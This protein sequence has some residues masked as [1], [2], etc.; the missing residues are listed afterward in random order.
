[1][2]LLATQLSFRAALTGDLEDV[3]AHF[4]DP[5]A[6]TGLAVYHNAY[7]VQLVDCLRETFER[8]DAWLGSEAFTLAAL[9]HIA[10][11]PPHGWTLGVYGEGFDTTLAR[12]YTDDPEVAE[13]A[14]LEWALSKAFAGADAE[15]LAANNL[16][17]VDWDR[18]RLNFVP[19]LQIAE[20]ATNVGAI[21]SALSAGEQP[22][23]AE[24]LP[25]PAA[26]L[27]WRQDYT[28]SFRTIDQNERRAL[29]QMLSGATFGEL[30]LAQVE[31]WGDDEGVRRA[32]EFLGQWLHDG[33]VTSARDSA[34]P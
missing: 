28:P 18:A 7:R 10:E 33:L 34:R 22:P 15:P 32:G 17:A 23:A 13:L 9:V 16:P 4:G 6:A 2:N 20:V 29:K 30:C 19:T 11:C 26:L 8:L 27:V 25:T 21:W 24:P 14:W 3:A 12:L 1:M 5:S 31:H